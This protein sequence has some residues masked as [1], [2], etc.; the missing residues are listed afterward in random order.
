MEFSVSEQT[1]G[2]AVCSGVLSEPERA[3]ARTNLAF[4]A[5]L[6]FSQ[7]MRVMRQPW[8]EMKVINPLGVKLAQ[9][10]AAAAFQKSGADR[11][12]LFDPRAD[13]ITLGASPYDALGFSPQAVQ[14]MDGFK[15]VYLEPQPQ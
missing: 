4:F 6:G 3:S 10:A 1:G 12:H 7:S 14:H 2:R 11:L 8:T 13:S 9:N 5:R 15:F